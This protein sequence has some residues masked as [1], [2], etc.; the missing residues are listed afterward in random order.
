[1]SICE[2]RWG[3]KEAFLQRSL[4]L[5]LALPLSRLS[6]ALIVSL[7][8][9]AT[10]SADAVLVRGQPLSNF[11]DNLFI[12]PDALRVILE[13]FSGPL[14]LLLYLIKKQNLDVLE[15]DVADLTKQYLAYIDLMRSAR[16]DLAAEYLLM[17]AI[18]IEMKSRL[19]LPRFNSDDEAD[20]EEDPRAAL[21]RQ[22]VEYEQMV[23]AA[24]QLFALPQEERDYFV[25]HLPPAA[26][27]PQDFPEV[28][29][30][31]LLRALQGLSLRLINNRSHP[32]SRQKI[33]MRERMGAILTSLQSSAQMYSFFS[34]FE[35][36]QS[37]SGLV[38]TFIAIL[39][40]LKERLIKLVAV[41]EDLYLARV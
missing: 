34:M 29:L 18:L 39:E 23:K 13:S 21:L 11:P 3:Q 30:G 24:E 6:Y 14:D 27:Q 37:R 12:P 22:L 40:L 26:A 41:E 8:T 35:G 9:E 28:E 25:A 36:E 20:E 16:I 10:V 1:M 33:S 17:A 5:S 19:L 4:I 38:V 31:D 32:V 15:V 2:Q 7:M